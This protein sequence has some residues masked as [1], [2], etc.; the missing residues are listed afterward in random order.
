MSKF[1]TDT[2]H[3]IVFDDG[4]YVDIR[5][6]ISWEELNTLTDTLKPEATKEDERENTLANMLFFIKNWNFREGDEVLEISKENLKRLRTEVWAVIDKEIAKV[7]KGNL[8]SEK[9]SE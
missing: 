6:N 1:A 4:E 3:K 8:K 7:I 2:V 9:K 5:D